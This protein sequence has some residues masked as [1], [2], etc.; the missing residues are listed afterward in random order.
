MLQLVSDVEWSRD[1][2]TQEPIQEETVVLGT[3]PIT[4]PQG[5][6]ERYRGW[7]VGQSMSQ[8]LPSHPVLR[9]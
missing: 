9:L 2:Q 1:S 3:A 6:Q 5:A 8:V 4:G 7:R